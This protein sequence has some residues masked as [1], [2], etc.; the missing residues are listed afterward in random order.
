[1][2]SEDWELSGIA[3]DISTYTRELVLDAIKDASAREAEARGVVRGIEIETSDAE[4]DHRRSE[5]GH[6]V[7]RWLLDKLDKASDDGMSRQEITRAMSS[8][9]RSILQSV[10]VVAVDDGLIKRST[11]GVRWVKL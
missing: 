9:D 5:R 1:M 11:D 4:R 10:L 6:R 3:A 8:R 7:L 2:T